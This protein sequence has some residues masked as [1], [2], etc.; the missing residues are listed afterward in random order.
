MDGTDAN[1]TIDAADL[2]AAKLSTAETWKTQLD[3]KMKELAGEG[4]PDIVGG[5]Y[6][7][8]NDQVEAMANT[9]DKVDLKLKLVQ[10]KANIQALHEIQKRLNQAIATYKTLQSPISANDALVASTHVEV[11]TND[12]NLCDAGAYKK[13]TAGADISE[14]VETKVETALTNGTLN[15]TGEKVKIAS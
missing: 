14:S 13:N 6:K 1:K 8:L 12:T 9:P 4:Y 5:T 7:V 3:T 2:D 11:A 10:I 15:E